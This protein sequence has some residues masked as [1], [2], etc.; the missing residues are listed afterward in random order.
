[1]LDKLLDGHLNYLVAKGLNYFPKIKYTDTNISNCYVG[2]ELF[3][4]V[5]STNYVTTNLIPYI[6]I[7]E[8]MKVDIS[9]TKNYVAST[10]TTLDN[11][12]YIGYGGSIADSTARA[13]VLMKFNNQDI[14]IF[15]DEV[16]H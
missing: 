15:Y 5:N 6:V 2:T 12:S 9:Y 13:F 14:E 11:I 10:I 4:V 16:L 1:M 7:D 8:D 3:A